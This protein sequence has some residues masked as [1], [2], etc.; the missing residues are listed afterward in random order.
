V[1]GPAT[2]DREPGLP[3]SLHPAHTARQPAWSPHRT[4]AAAVSWGLDQD[5]VIS[6]CHISL[7]PPLAAENPWAMPLAKAREVVVRAAAAG[8]RNPAKAVGIAL[9]YNVFAVMTREL[10]D[11]ENDLNPPRLPLELGGEAPWK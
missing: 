1:H 6:A 7:A 5:F 8:S 3:S 11:A 2:H 9:L 10:S 4:A